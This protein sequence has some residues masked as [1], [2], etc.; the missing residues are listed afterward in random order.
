ML[1]DP[2]ER[3]VPFQGMMSAEPLGLGVVGSG[4]SFLPLGSLLTPSCRIRE[5]RNPGGQKGIDPPCRRLNTGSC[6]AGWPPDSNR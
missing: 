3:K 4:G 6:R 5:Y 2:E 1:V